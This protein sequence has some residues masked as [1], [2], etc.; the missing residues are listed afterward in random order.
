M[1]LH[2]ESGPPCRHMETLLQRTADGSS[3]GVLRWYANSHAAQ[4]KR[5][6]NFLHGLVE[7]REHL[8]EARETP[9]PEVMDRLTNGPW[10]EVS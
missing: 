7:M 10:R 1:N 2:A 9:D 3:R 5:C 4:C 6:G 8:H